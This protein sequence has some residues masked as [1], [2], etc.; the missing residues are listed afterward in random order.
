MALRRRADPRR[1]TG[2]LSARD[3]IALPVAHKTGKRI[4]RD[5]ATRLPMMPFSRLIV[6]ALRCESLS[7][8]Q[9]SA[10]S[11]V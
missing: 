6:N 9:N 8:F 11:L 1:S 10:V 5:T 3:L 7:L 2:T 4:G